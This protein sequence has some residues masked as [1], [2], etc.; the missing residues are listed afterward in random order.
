MPIFVGLL[1]KWKP[2][3]TI[4]MEYLKQLEQEDVDGTQ[5]RFLTYGKDLT[6]ITFKYVFTDPKLRHPFVVMPANY[7]NLEKMTTDVQKFEIE[8]FETIDMI[9]LHIEGVKDDVIYKIYV[10]KQ[11]LSS[12]NQEVTFNFSNQ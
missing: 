5:N 2:A 10:Y 9:P 1:P 7:P 4:T 12:M 11:A 3:H 8:A 6:S